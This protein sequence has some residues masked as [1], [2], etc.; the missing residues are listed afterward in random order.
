MASDCGCKLSRSTIRY[1]RNSNRAGGE[2]G[3]GMYLLSP[4]NLIVTL[5]L[6]GEKAIPHRAPQRGAP[7]HSHNSFPSGHARTKAR[8]SDKIVVCRDGGIGRR[9]RLKIVYP[10][11][12]RVRFP[13][14]A[15]FGFASRTL[16]ASHLCTYVLLKI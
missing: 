5:R 1:L 3:G 14:S 15:P 2:S 8:I 11:G 7:T 16:M 10:Q 4:R 12:V 6:I 9:A 13:L